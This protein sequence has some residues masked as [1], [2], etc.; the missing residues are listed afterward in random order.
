[1]IHIKPEAGHFHADFDRQRPPIA[2]VEPGQR[3]CFSTPDVAWGLENHKA[4]GGP[5]AKVEP[6]S[7]GPCLVG[8]VAIRGVRPGQTLAITLEEVRPGPWGWTMAGGKGFFNEDLNRALGVIDDFTLLRWTLTDGWAQNHL[9]HRLKMSPFPGMLGMPAACDGPQCGWTPRRT[10]GNMDCRYL[11][12]GNQLFLPIEVEG[13]LLSCGDG[14]A[15]QADGECSGTAI[16][17]PMEAVT[18]KLDLI[19]LPITQPTIKTP[20]GWVVLGFGPNLDRAQQQALS[21]MLDWMAPRLKLS[22]A[23]TLAL[24]SLCCHLHITQVVNGV[25]GVQA[26]WEEDA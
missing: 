1:V 10:G 7:D 24:A 20:R 3:V 6:R 11:V 14:H 12:A 19:D 5:R 25:V 15:L 21:A 23:E 8:P 9:G 2:T 16:E 22:R 13:G 4:E 17:C 26:V 18:L